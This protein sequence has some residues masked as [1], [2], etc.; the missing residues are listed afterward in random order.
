MIKK[1][2]IEKIGCTNPESVVLSI[3]EKEYDY[4]LTKEEIYERLPQLGDERVITIS[5]LN[6]A[7][8]NMVRYG[9]D[10]DINYVKNR[11]YYSL[12]VRW[13]VYGNFYKMYD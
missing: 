13:G 9:R 1:E 2:Y 6:T 12:R 3:L 10:V 11:A 7:L 4:C 8:R 5:Q